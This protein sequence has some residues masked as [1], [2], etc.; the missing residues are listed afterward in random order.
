MQQVLD[1]YSKEVSTSVMQT[2]WSKCKAKLL[3]E[4]GWEII[5]GPTK[6]NDPNSPPVHKA[7]RI[8]GQFNRWFYRADMTDDERK[9]GYRF[10]EHADPDHASASE[11]ESGDT[12]VDDELDD[13]DLL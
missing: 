8:A 9:T 10:I 7:F 1:Q 6:A 13:N 2:A 3:E 12:Q 5:E 11:S 4:G